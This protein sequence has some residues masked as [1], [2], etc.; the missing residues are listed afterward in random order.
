MTGEAAR[1]DALRWVRL[2]GL[3]LVVALGLGLVALPWPW[4]LLPG[5]LCLAALTV[6]IVALVKVRAAK[7]RGS[8]T[9]VLVVGL[10]LAAF[11]SL[12]ASGQVV[13]W[14]E[15]GAYSEC[16]AGAITQ[17]AKDSCVAQLERS[18]DDR[19]R[20]VLERTRQG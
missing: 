15:Y 11:M 7:V 3:T 9:P 13:L 2:F 4:L 14:R 10:I 6:G 19:M 20:Q 8:V 18:L 12:A 17:Q 5:L 16:M 1:A